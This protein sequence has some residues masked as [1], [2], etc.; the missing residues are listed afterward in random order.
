MPANMRLVPEPIGWRILVVMES[1]SS[2]ER[3][4]DERVGDFEAGCEK[5]NRAGYGG[6]P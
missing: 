1:M 4:T 3:F 6:G 2:L 5:D